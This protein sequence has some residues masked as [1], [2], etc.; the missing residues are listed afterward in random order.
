MKVWKYDITWAKFR[1]SWEYRSI[2]FIFKAFAIFL[3][4]GYTYIGAE[5]FLI[6]VRKEINKHQDV[7][8]LRGVIASAVADDQLTEVT[9]WVKFRPAAETDAIIDIIT[10][11]SGSLETSIF[12]E[13][14]R[15]RLEQGKK[16]DALFW[17]QLGRYRLRFDLIR[18]SASGSI[19]KIGKFLTFFRS[20][21]IDDLLFQRPELVK[22]SVQQVLDFDKK[23]PAHN[24]PSLICNA[25][26]RL[27]NVNFVPSESKAWAGIRDVLRAV[28]E[29]SLKEMDVP[30]T[31]V[32]KKK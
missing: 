13:I 29:A 12:F 25:V 11:E 22:K 20:P 15:R 6:L 5:S 8:A 18:C 26:N 19:E 2:A 1:T 14:S 21:E 31:P 3:M 9:T 17:S 30:K 16:E 10:P 28:T 7:T 27:E 32:Q 4:V 23:Y 24:S